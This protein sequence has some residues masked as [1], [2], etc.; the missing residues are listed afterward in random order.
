MAAKKK[1]TQKK[2]TTTE[3]SSKKTSKKSKVK[4]MYS[5]VGLTAEYMSI[6]LKKKQTQEGT[7][8]L[9]S[10]PLVEGLPMTLTLKKGETIEVTPEQLE[11]LRTLKVVETQEEHDKRLAFINNLPNQFPED[12]SAVEK[13]EREHQLLTAWDA[14]NKIYCDKLIICD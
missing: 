3:K 1:S 7:I 8:N 12:L 11:T 13:A 14:Q 4:L 6:P 9:V 2:T 10:V 5:P